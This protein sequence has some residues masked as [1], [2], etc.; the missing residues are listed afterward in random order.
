MDFNHFLSS[1]YPDPEYGGRRLYA[2]MVEQEIGRA[3]V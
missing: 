1:Y 2:D 3:H